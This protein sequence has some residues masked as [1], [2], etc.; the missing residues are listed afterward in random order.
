[1]R[2][3]LIFLGASLFFIF[4]SQGVTLGANF[5]CS[6]NNYQPN[7]L[8]HSF[9]GI[10]A[11]QGATPAKFTQIAEALG[12]TR[13]G[14]VRESIKWSQVE[15]TRG[16][17]SWQEVDTK[18]EALARESIRPLAIIVR[19]PAWASSRPN[20]PDADIYPPENLY[21]WKSFIRQL[22][23]RYGK[24]GRNIIKDW[25]IW[26]EP[27]VAKFF[28]G[29]PDDYIKLLNA[30][31]DVI[32]EEDPQARVWGPATFAIYPSQEKFIF[33][34]KAV[35]TGKMDVFSVH[36]YAR[37]VSEIYN[38]TRSIRQYLDQH[39]KSNLPLALTETNLSGPDIS[40]QCPYLG[41]ASDQTQ[42]QTL[43]DIYL[44]NASAGAKFVF[45]FK[46]NDT[47]TNICTN[48]DMNRN[49][50]L[51]YDLSKKPSFNRLQNLIAQFVS[52]PSPSPSPPA[53]IPGDI[54]DEGDTPTD[55]V[56]IYDYN[57]L[58]ADFGKTGSPGFIPADII[59]DG[60]VDIFDYNTV[61]GNFGQ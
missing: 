18:F 27:D 29:T 31:Y 42:P 7:W 38:K 39:G 3:L 21:T 41:S 16:N 48:D 46:A 1:M 4:S 36:V 59:K 19:T 22:V 50:V 30:A 24:P 6:I 10:A 33:T 55:Q 14:M 56:N 49:G 26:N 34:Q 23:R 2:K 43:T 58:V 11:N 45:W 28:K 53:S 57:L 61:V 20:S 60:R 52:L 37:T 54:I 35:E 40:G 17:F 51:R 32:K 47:P 25:E 9:F 8:N 5:S 44:C 13:V 15:E 12:Q